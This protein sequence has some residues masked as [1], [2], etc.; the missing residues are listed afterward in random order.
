MSFIGTAVFSTNRRLGR[1]LNDATTSAGVDVGV[2]VLG[3]DGSSLAEAL[4]NRVF[5]EFLQNVRRSQTYTRMR[6]VADD[7]VVDLGVVEEAV[8]R[9]ILCRWSLSDCMLVSSIAGVLLPAPTLASSDALP[10]TTSM[11]T[12]SL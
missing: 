2:S 7:G 9:N 8:D 10:P 1:R 3:S 4:C 12:M 11:T 5:H 6:C